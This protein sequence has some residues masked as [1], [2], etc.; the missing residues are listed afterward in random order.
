MKLA[1]RLA[2]ASALLVLS[3]GAAHAQFL[4]GD[5]K[6]P[7]EAWHKADGNFGAMLIVTDRYTDLAKGWGE[8]AK[9]GEKASVTLT[10]T[11]ERGDA[12]TAAITFSGCAAGIIGRCLCDAD[13]LVLRPDGSTY[14]THRR[15]PVWRDKPPVEGSA[16]LADGRLKLR[17]EGNDPLGTWTIRAIVRDRIANSEVRLEW[18]IQVKA[19][20]LAP[21]QRG[22]WPMPASTP[23]P[24]ETGSIAGI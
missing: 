18:P 12:V 17:L 22:D 23:A 20:S 16:Q 6:A 4:Q 15:V 11:T 14:A 10:D 7:E 19:E 13:F 2:L 3:G 5:E 24:L 1:K 8:P 21:G 9:D